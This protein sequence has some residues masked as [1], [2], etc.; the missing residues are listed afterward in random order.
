MS[1]SRADQRLFTTTRGRIITLLRRAP[2]T[3]EELAQALDLTDNAIRAPMATL[4]RDG[5]VVQ[6]G[7]QQGARKPSIIYTLNAEG[8]QLF[9]EAY[10]PAL[11]ELLDVLAEQTAPEAFAE[12]LRVVGRRQ[13][14]QRSR[15]P[16]HKPPLEC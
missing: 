4:A 10:E 3:V 13:P 8:E 7:T 12:L 2:R 14:R 5:I 6:R 16:A 11:R 1:T 9:P 15:A